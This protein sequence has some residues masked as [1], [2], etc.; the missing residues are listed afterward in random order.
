MLLCLW[1]VSG[2]LSGL[3]IREIKASDGLLNR[4]VPFFSFFT[5]A[6]TR[7]YLALCS[8]VGICAVHAARPPHARNLLEIAKSR[9]LHSNLQSS[10][11]P[12]Y[13]PPQEAITNK[14]NMA[15]ETPQNPQLN[16]QEEKARRAAEA[17]EQAQLPYKW[18]QTIRD[19]DVTIPV[20]GHLRGKDL[21]VVLAKDRIRVGVKGESPIIDVPN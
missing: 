15:D 7:V 14:V 9:L 5:V 4:L 18:T 20:P 21:D 12:F 1:Q 8:V 13:F 10:P 17:A 3:F 2:I 11:S 6:C 16:E 19:V